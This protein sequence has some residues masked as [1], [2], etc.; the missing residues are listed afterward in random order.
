MTPECLEENSRSRNL[1]L[2]SA[3]VISRV[4]IGIVLIPIARLVFTHGPWFPRGAVTWASQL[5]QWDAT[6]YL[7]IARTGY[8][9]IQL[10]AFY[11]AYP[12]LIRWVSP[13]FGFSAGSFAISWVAGIFA[14]WG[15]VDVARRFA[16]S[17][18]AWWAGLL[19]LWNPLS[20]FFIA[21]YPESLLVAAMVWSLRFC[22]DRKWWP[23]ALLAGLASCTMPQGIASGAVVFVALVLIDRTWKGVLRGVA[24]G[25]LGELGILTYWLY[26]WR[27]TGDAFIEQRAEKLGWGTHLTYPLHAIFDEWS[28]AF[29]HLVPVGFRFAFAIDEV[30]GFLGVTLAVIAIFLSRRDHGLI[31]PA[32]LLAIG[33]L[34]S[35]VPINAG[36]S[37]TA[38]YILFLAPLYVVIAAL[39]Q[40]PNAE[41]RFHLALILFLVSAFLAVLFGLLYNF[42]W[43]A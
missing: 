25:A 8:S 31:L 41:L 27:T 1:L 24:F 17:Q 36:I 35:V 21:G 12:L 37:A 28:L 23:A 26:C 15:V 3:F 40:R 5:N 29:S 39:L 6:L 9:D 33:I 42:G 34:I 30:T 22:L 11:P 2:S 4:I 43:T 13:V 16:S 19:L 20:V 7:S 18:V 14:V 38:R 32:T 10:H